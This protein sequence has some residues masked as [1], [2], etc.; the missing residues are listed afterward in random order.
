MFE[1]NVLF[2]LIKEALACG[3]SKKLWKEIAQDVVGGTRKSQAPLS[4]QCPRSASPL[5]PSDGRDHLSF[6]SGSLARGR[7]AVSTSES[8]VQV[9]ENKRELSGAV[10]GEGVS[11]PR[12]PGTWGPSCLGHLLLPLPPA[13][14]EP[15]RSCQ[16]VLLLLRLLLPPG[17]VEVC[18]GRHHQPRLL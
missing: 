9:P 6:R 1:R 10:E 14:R 17:G 16:V 15:V 11:R 5:P 18:P 2:P 8:E 3:C 12:S 13:H 4:P 7:G